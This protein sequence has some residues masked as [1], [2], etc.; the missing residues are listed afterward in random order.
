LRLWDF[1]QAAY[2]RPGVEAACL[3]L[4]DE[5]GQCVPLMLWR[6]WTVGEGRAVE[7]ELLRSAAMT[8][9]AWDEAAVVPLRQVRRRLKPRFPPIPDASRLELREGL[10]AAELRAE[11][12]L[13]ET[14]ES[15]T[16]KPGQ[17]SESAVR[18]LEMVARAW[19]VAAPAEALAA[20]A[21]AAL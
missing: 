9:R 6:L 3:A 7:D 2:A 5:H 10:K 13:L 16:P 8:A 4:Q 19:G 17:A 15:L 12:I 20:L 18:S 14:L 21:A 1:A 11:R